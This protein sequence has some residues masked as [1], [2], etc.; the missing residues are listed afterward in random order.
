MGLH[1]AVARASSLH[2]KGSR[3][4]VEL[5][6]DRLQLL[7]YVVVSIIQKEPNSEPKMVSDPLDKD[8]N[9]TRHTLGRPDAVAGD[10]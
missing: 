6:K 8:L 1:F 10:V 7:L 3:I 4:T 5:Q 9:P 2:H